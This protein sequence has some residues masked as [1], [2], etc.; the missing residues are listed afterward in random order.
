MK[1]ASLI[2][3]IILLISI[4]SAC[5]KVNTTGDNKEA[6]SDGTADV[7]PSPAPTAS[8]TAE[9]SP[10][11]SEKPTVPP[12][13][14]FEPVD[15]N[16]PDDHW[17][18]N[19]A[20][21]PAVPLDGMSAPEGMV[22]LKELPV[23]YSA[24]QA[25]A[26]GCYG[27]Y[28]ANY[29]SITFGEE[30]LL[31]FRECVQSGIPCSI[32]KYGFVFM[33]SPVPTITDMYFDGENIIHRTYTRDI[34]KQLEYEEVSVEQDI[35]EKYED[36]LL[37][38]DNDAE[39]ALADGCI[40]FTPDSPEPIGNSNE[41]WN[42]FYN[43]VTSGKKAAVR[44]FRG[45]GE[46]YK[47]YMIHLEFDGKYF[48][49]TTL[50]DDSRLHSTVF[51]NLNK[52][53]DINWMQLKRIDHYMLTYSSEY[54][55]DDCIKSATVLSEPSLRSNYIIIDWDEVYSINSPDNVTMDDFTAGNDMQFPDESALSDV[56]MSLRSIK[57][58][59]AKA[60]TTRALLESILPYKPLIDVCSFN[61]MK[62]G[63]DSIGDYPAIQEFFARPNAYYELIKLKFN[64]SE[65]FDMIERSVYST[66]F[67]YY[68]NYV[69]T[70]LH[71]F[72]TQ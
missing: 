62:Q 70:G 44:I 35:T 68:E 51:T 58:D 72:K 60:M 10:A 41:I 39:K 12:Q 1:K 6:A 54:T 2:L 11:P 5:S 14:S 46:Q 63:M 42:S 38:Y 7:T 57:Q 37:G 25:E 64:G 28:F 34:E 27:K 40:V 29:E 66:I 9:P 71:E 3:I 53:E 30:K 36:F 55:Y 52:C 61:T 49:L 13:P 20:D 65:E 47:P 8:P 16:F 17:S 15:R 69:L 31:A 4:F 24:E 33:S 18:K 48:V 26:D 59:D 22:P 21:A 45:N 56:A 50:Y 23:D 32:R 67:L 19:I 43:K